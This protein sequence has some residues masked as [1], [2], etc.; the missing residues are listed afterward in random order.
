LQPQSEIRLA[1]VVA[2]FNSELTEKMLKQA[3]KSSTELD[4]LVTYVCKVPGSFDIPLTVQTLLKKDDVDAVATLGA[5]VQGETKHDEVI[6]Y[7]L[8]EK[9]ADLSLRYGKPVAL[10]VAGPGMTWEQAEAR[11]EEYSARSVSAAV[12]MALR[13]RE[14]EKPARSAYP[15]VI[16]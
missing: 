1:L 6:A 5:I 10:G 16:E 12:K 15:V 4:A 9:I 14:L 13:Q 2:E 11:I 8:T 7:A 3:L